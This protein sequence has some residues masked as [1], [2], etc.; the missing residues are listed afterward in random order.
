[1][2]TGE[3]HASR[4]GI[5]PEEIS[6]TIPLRMLIL[7]D[8]PA[9]ADLMV[10]ALHRVGF[11]PSWQR[12][13]TEADYLDSLHAD[14]DV[15]L[16]DYALPQFNALHALHLMQ[17]R[18]LDIPFIV[19]TG[20]INEGAAME[21][22]RHGA[23]DYLLKDW[24]VLLGPAVT[25][26]LQQKQLRHEKRQSD[27]AL[28]A[29][30]ARFR[31]IAEAMPIP[32]GITR[33]SD[34]KILYANRH[35]G[36][37]FGLS[38]EALVGYEALAFY[39]DPADRQKLLTALSKDGYLSHYEMHLKKAD[40]TPF[41]VIASLQTLTFNGA[42]AIL[43]GFYDITE[44]KM[45][46]EAL[47]QAHQ[48]TAQLL[49]AIPS[50]L[51]GM[52]S[53]RRITWWNTTAERTFGLASAEVIGRP[54]SA[55]RLS[56]DRAAVLAGLA[57]CGNTGV[58]VRVDDV[59]F[60]RPDGKDRFLGVTIN[61][62]RGVSGDRIGFLLLGADITDRK[63]LES[64]LAQAQKL[65][66]IGYLAAGIAHE[67]NTPTQFVGDNTH[68][69]QEAFKELYGLLEQYT[70]LVQA[71]KEGT[72]T[73]ALIQGVEATA[74]AIDVA[75]LLDEVP[76]AL[77][78][79][80]EGIERV[81]EIVRAMK[82][83]SHPGSEEKL[84]I[85]LNKAIE[86]TITVTR[87]EWKYVAEMVTDFDP[88][89]PLVPCLPGELNQVVLNLVVNAAH[90]IADVVGNDAMGKGRI[91]V[92]TRLDGDWVEIRIADTGTGIP[93]AIRDKVFD[94][95]FTT[96]EVGKGT[97]Q[98]LAIAYDVVVRKHNG[99]I[100]F[101]TEEG[102]GTTLIIRLPFEASGLR[103]VEVV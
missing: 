47:R 77:Q 68:F 11:A 30:E 70:V 97:G 36:P 55:C 92:S 99:R 27:A 6:M 33:V 51:I 28:H 34:G 39:Y 89:L 25:R 50:I 3:V 13:E 4:S 60:R 42:S 73:E 31:A 14:L 71:S 9:D 74:E 102:R 52:D 82:E 96:K 56:W 57:A 18:G 53:H 2:V 79:S 63:L 65:E 98:G 91:T 100:T 61:P 78:Q 46:E 7:E 58:P 5:S 32:M 66:S 54:L 16:A 23:T 90:A 103:E 94:P 62:M 59:P 72:V 44:N 10:H 19:L 76:R 81:A 21:C 69:L 41:W 26:A 49:T 75:Y 64:Q 80:L 8:L 20:T 12:V 43:A 37:A 95:F 87:N 24:L 1:M 84:F 86:S 67:I 29:S 40:G 48:Q 93:V 101:E 88:A 35:F 15:I 22:V 17:E 85:D 38:T 45:A 83:F